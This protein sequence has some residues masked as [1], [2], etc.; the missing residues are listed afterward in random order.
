MIL[1]NCFES[2]V[3]KRIFI[4]LDYDGDL[5]DLAVSHEL[6]SLLNENGYMLRRSTMSTLPPLRAPSANAVRAV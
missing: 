6:E 3:M 2:G 1:E 4:E 5:S